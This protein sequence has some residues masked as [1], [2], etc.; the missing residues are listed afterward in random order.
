MMSEREIMMSEKGN[1]MSERDTM[2]S[3][4]E[5][6]RIKTMKSEHLNFDLVEL[7]SKIVEL[8]LHHAG[9]ELGPDYVAVPLGRKEGRHI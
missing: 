5:S 6:A 9:G 8:V 4:R 7:E 1:M 3:G 2:M